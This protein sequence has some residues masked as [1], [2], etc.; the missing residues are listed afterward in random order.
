MTVLTRFSALLLF[1]VS[2]T[3][4]VA[5]GK[6][7]AESRDTGAATGTLLTVNA[8]QPAFPE[9]EDMLRQMAA[10]MMK[11]QGLDGSSLTGIEPAAGDAASAENQ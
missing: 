2:I 1:I 4:G 8:L 9:S 11:S 5:A 6:I 10:D 3:A 7:Y